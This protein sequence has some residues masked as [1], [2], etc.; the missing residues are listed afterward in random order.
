[1]LFDVEP[2][3][4]TGNLETPLPSIARVRVVTLAGNSCAAEVVEG[5]LNPIQKGYRV[6]E[7]AGKTR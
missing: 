3:V 7:V 1:M 6:T 4:R 5:K 2:I